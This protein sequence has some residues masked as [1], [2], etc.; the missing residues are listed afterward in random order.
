MIR[1]TR[2]TLDTC[3][4]SV[5]YE[6]DDTKDENTRTHSPKRIISRCEA[7]S[8]VL[9]STVAAHWSAITEENTRKNRV[10]AFIEAN[11]PAALVGLTWSFDKTTR[12]LSINAPNATSNQKTS[13][14]NWCNNNLGVGKV[15]IS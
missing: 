8:D 5:E 15:V 1:T 7:H 11:A 14:Q 12:V 6:W 2:W 10:Y 9:L 13:A 4:C 3:G